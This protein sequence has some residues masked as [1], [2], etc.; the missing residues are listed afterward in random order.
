MSILIDTDEWKNNPWYQIHG[1]QHSDYTGF[2]V[3]ISIC[4]IVVLGLI[5]INVVIC[6]CTP[7]KQYWRDPNTGNR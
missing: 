2:Y 7:Y 6:C 5:A 3:G 4:T 1:K